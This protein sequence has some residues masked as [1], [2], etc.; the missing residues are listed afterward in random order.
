[1]GENWRLVGD[2]GSRLGTGRDLLEVGRKSQE[3]SWDLRILGRQRWDLIGV[4]LFGKA[5]V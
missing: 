4:E 3:V 2:V 1:V 5:G